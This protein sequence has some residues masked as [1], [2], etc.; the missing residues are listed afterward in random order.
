M[1]NISFSQAFSPEN[2]K[3][4][5]QQII[6]MLSEY[7]QS[8][9]EDFD[10]K[11]VL[12]STNWESI[13]SECLSPTSS[14]SNDWQSFVQKIID[15]SQ[16]LHHPN[17]IGHQVAVPLPMASAIDLVS[18][19]L[20]NSTAI[21]EMGPIHAA[22]ETKL[23][24][25]VAQKIGYGGDSGGFINAGGSLGNL[26][27]LLAARQVKSGYDV[28]NDGIQQPLAVLVSDQA[29]YCVERATQIMGLGKNGAISIASNRDFQVT[30][31]A[32]DLS[33]QEALKKYRKV[34]AV[35]GSCCNTGPGTFENLQIIA[36]FCKEHDLWFHVD[37]AHGAP[38]VLSEKYSNL[39]NGISQADS[40]V[41]DFHKMMMMPSLCTGVVFRK[42]ENSYMALKQHAPY[43][44]SN[45]K[46][47][48]WQAISQR[49][50]ECTK[51]SM[52]LKAYFCLR[53]YGENFF[54]S[55]IDYTFDMGKYFADIIE[56]NSNFELAVIP[57]GNIVCF[58]FMS[59]NG[60]LDTLQKAIC[61]KVVQLGRFYIVNTTLKDKVYLRTTIMNPFTTKET[62]VKLLSHIHE[63]AT[64]LQKENI[65]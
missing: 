24:E 27:A 64:N 53:H 28:W 29:H 17:Y 65:Q 13:L 63:V 36:E 40:V 9:H 33:F 25:W 8:M 5:T 22:I 26:M 6:N 62:L 41:W 57:Q 18:S 10:T 56:K 3:Y 59:N 46:T 54:A 23:I 2:F 47:D 7:L 11:K 15:Y 20:N 58:R 45:E 35:V 50:M 12:K 37:G 34:I 30:R 49:T 16:H 51:P 43:L 39:T 14:F 19:F 44:Y 52:G 4:N 61:K 31:K 55:Y 48:D 1:T 60:C 21:V 42:K 38:V 32:L